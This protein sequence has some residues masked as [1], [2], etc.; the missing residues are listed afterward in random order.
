VLREVEVSD[1]EQLPT[2]KAMFVRTD[3]TIWWAGGFNGYEY[4]P[5]S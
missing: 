5:A 3:E 2:Y 4:R 1:W